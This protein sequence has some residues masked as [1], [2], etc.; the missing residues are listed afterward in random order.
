MVF[1]ESAQAYRKSCNKLKNEHDAI[2][3]QWLDANVLQHYWK[4]LW[5][6]LTYKD[7]VLK[8]RN[9]DK[10]EIDPFNN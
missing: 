6:L 2:A 1:L 7:S 9:E 5:S 3:F 10:T 8:I 4:D